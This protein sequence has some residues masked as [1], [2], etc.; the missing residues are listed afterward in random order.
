VAPEGGDR[1]QSLADGHLDL[2]DDRVTVLSVE[3]LDRLSRVRRL[4]DVRRHQ[5]GALDE[6]PD[7]LAALRPGVDQHHAEGVPILSWFGRGHQKI[8]AIA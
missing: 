6:V 2:D 5:P 8:L 4:A 1:L 3:K 7:E